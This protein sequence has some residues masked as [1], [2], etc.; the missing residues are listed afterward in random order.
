MDVAAVFP[1][2]VEPSEPVQQCQGPFDDVAGAAESGA[3]GLAVA[4]DLGTDA[5]GVEELAVFVM[6]VA[7]VGLHGPGAPAGRPGLP[8]IGRIASIKGSSWVTSLRLPPVRVTA[9]GYTVGVGGQVVFG[10]GTATISRAPTGFEPPRNALRC[11]ESTTARSIS[12]CPLRR[13]SSSSTS[14]RRSQ[15]LAS[16]QS[17]NLRQHVIPHPK[18]S[19]WG[20]HCHWMPV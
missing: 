18:P 17:R 8:R 5:L 4:G 20:S 6:V 16:F 14:W 15:T 2:D 9:K 7:A 1:S 11:E 19:S 3:V 10:A 13:G 12:S